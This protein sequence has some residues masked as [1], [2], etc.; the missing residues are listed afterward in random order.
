MVGNPLKTKNL[1]VVDVAANDNGQLITNKT[2]PQASFYQRVLSHSE[3]DLEEREKLS[4]LT[5]LL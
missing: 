1:P 2:K 4:G 5:I 3:K